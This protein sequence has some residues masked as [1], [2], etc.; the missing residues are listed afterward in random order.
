MHGL[1]AEFGEQLIVRR[2]DANIH[3]N[4]ALEFSYGLRGHPAFAILDKTGEAAAVYIGPQSAET[5]R[6]AITA[7]L[8]PLN[9]AR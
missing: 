2:L 4:E 5:L 7:V 8:N 1:E 6:G 3:E 9:S